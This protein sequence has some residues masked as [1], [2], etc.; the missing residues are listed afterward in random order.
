MLKRWYSST[1]TSKGFIKTLKYK[2][3]KSVETFTYLA[4]EIASTEKDPYSKGM[5]G[6]KLIG[7]REKRRRMRFAGRCR[8]AKQELASDLLLWTPRY[9]R[10][11]VGRPATTYVDR[12]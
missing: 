8:R 12:L 6:S 7:C 1:T 10:T 2:P 9:G 11:R 5:G 4:S 3:L